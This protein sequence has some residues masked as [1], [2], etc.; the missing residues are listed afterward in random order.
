MA[1]NNVLRKKVVSLH[2]STHAV[3]SLEEMRLWVGHTC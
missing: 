1:S 3:V 2:L